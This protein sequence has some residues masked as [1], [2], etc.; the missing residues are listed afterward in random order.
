[1]L[2]KILLVVLLTGLAFA[3]LAIRVIMKKDG[4]FSKSCSHADPSTGEKKHC[5]CDGSDPQA[6]R[7]RNAE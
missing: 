2:I 5:V 7:N 4:K 3:S 1:M 6:C